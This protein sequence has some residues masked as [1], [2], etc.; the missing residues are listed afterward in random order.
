MSKS[1]IF[2]SSSRAVANILSRLLRALIDTQTPTR[3]KKLTTQWPDCTYHISVHNSEIWLHR[4]GNKPTMERKMNACC[5]S[6]TKSC[7]ALWYCGLQH[8]RISCP[9]LSLE[10]AQI[11]VHWVSDAIQPSHPLSSPSLPAFSLSQHQSLFQWDSPSHQLAKVLELQLQH[12][13]FQ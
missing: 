8:A 12:Q 5:C 10:F 2:S 6:V 1:R 13:C 7:P 11:H 3:W 9:S 4:K